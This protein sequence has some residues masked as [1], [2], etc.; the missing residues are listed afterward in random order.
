MTGEAK[1]IEA[2]KMALEPFR[3]DITE[4]GVTAYANDSHPF[5]EEYVANE[6]TMVLDGHIFSL[7][8]LYDFV[9]AVPPI[10]DPRAHEAYLKGIYVIGK[11]GPESKKKAKRFFEQV[12]EIEPDYAPAYA[13]LAVAYS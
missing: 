9:R 3:F 11:A 2:A 12:I 1:Y 7:F 4:G 13:G 6:P 10:L 5:Y 8:G